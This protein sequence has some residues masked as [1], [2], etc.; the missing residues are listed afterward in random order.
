[1]VD[2]LMEIVIK[3]FA[4]FQVYNVNENRSENEA[5][6]GLHI[7]RFPGSEKKFYVMVTTKR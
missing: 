4:F 5:V 1:M 6:T 7:E 3:L 2:C